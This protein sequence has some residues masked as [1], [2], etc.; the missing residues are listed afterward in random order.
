MPPSQLCC[1]KIDPNFVYLLCVFCCSFPASR[2]FCQYVIACVDAIKRNEPSLLLSVYCLVTHATDTIATLIG[3][4]SSGPKW[5]Q[6]KMIEGENVSINLVMF[7]CKHP[8]MLFLFVRMMVHDQARLLMRIYCA[9]IHCCWIDQIQ[10][11][12]NTIIFLQFPFCCHN[13]DR[14]IRLSSS[15][16]TKYSHE[17]DKQYYNLLFSCSWHVLMFVNVLLFAI[18]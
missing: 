3:L 6:C 9:H 5:K 14:A 11:W 7:M 17:N 16:D 12:I 8:Q 10:L 2:T 1:N 4:I 15:A 13:H 18:R